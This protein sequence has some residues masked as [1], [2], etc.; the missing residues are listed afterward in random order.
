MTVV[1]VVAPFAP[2]TVVVVVVAMLEA[3]ADVTVR[4][5]KGA[6]I[7]ALTVTGVVATTGPAATE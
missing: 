2:T 1:V 4:A 3:V 6:V 5:G 7:V